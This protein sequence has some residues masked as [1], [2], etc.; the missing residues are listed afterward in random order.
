MF[1]PELVWPMLN[2]TGRY[3][4]RILLRWKSKRTHERRCVVIHDAPSLCVKKEVGN[5]DTPPLNFYI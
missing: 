1:L 5:F 2:Q 4:L 3:I